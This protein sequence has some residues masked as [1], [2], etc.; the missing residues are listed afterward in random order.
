MSNSSPVI[1]PDWKMRVVV[2]PGMAASGIIQV[3]GYGA[4]YNVV[5]MVLRIDGDHFGNRPHP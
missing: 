3:V 5:Q 2:S 4:V 1:T